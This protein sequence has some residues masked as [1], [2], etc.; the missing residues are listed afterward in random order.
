[1]INENHL[2]A[3]ILRGLLGGKERS[4]CDATS[5]TNMS[6]S[7]NLLIPTKFHLAGK[8]RK[9]LFWNGSKEVLFTFTQPIR[10]Y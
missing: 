10:F 1:M 2:K 5:K 4:V 7:F 3:A 6:I 8:P 9:I